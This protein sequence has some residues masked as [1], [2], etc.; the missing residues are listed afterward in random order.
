MKKRLIK[1]NYNLFLGI[2]LFL[3]AIDLGHIIYRY[4]NINLMLFLML[5]Y[6]YSNF[7]NG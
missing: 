2:F 6:V 5:F 1:N 4:F 7:F 3:G